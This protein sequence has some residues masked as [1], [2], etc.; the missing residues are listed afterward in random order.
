MRRDERVAE[1]Q[2]RRGFS[3]SSEEKR[4]GS[5]EERRPGQNDRFSY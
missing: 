5:S 3:Q 4:G 1:G 2:V